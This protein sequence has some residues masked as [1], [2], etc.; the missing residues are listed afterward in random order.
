MDN[1]THPNPVGI[2]RRYN[3]TNL[4]VTITDHANYGNRLQNYA[5]QTLLSQYGDVTTAYMYL[6]MTSGLKKVIRTGKQIIRP[7]YAPFV[8]NKRSLEIKRRK[9]CN[10]FSKAYIHEND[11]ALSDYK[12]LSG[13]RGKQYNRVVIGSDQVWNPQW[14]SDRELALRLGSFVPD[15]IPIISY[16]ASIGSTEVRKSTIPIFQKYLPRMRDIS[17]R[18]FQGAELIKGMTGLN[19]TVVLDPTLMIDADKWLKISNIFVKINDSYVLSYF[20]GKPSEDQE[21][22]IQEYAKAHNCRVRRILDLRDQETYIAGPQDFV[23]LIS[24]AEYVFT[25]SYHACCFS[26]LF[27]KQFTVFNRASNQR[28][29]NMNSRMETLFQLFHLKST[30]RDTGLAPAIDYEKVNHLLSAHRITSKKWLDSAMKA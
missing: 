28:I 21:Q 10:A 8:D 13:K 26:M 5:I 29:G 12:G 1:T 3:M 18:E 27:Q 9:H 23:E 17:V 20:L 16:A 2:I 22:T 24:K 14:I 6:G 11:F 19:A 7:L 4:I 30:M 25:D 15:N